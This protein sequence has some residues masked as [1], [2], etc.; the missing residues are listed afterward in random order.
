MTVVFAGFL[1]VFSRDYV[2]PY[3]SP[4]G[5]VALAVV[6]GMFAAGFAWMRQLSGADPVQPFLS[7]PGQQT[8]GED[9]R[10]VA[11]LTGL[12]PAAVQTLTTEPAA[13]G[14]GR[15]GAR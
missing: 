2:R 1:V 14:P 3:S 10:L 9:L 7:R 4:A 8:T 6:I 11:G 5:Q 12:S 13:A 15:A